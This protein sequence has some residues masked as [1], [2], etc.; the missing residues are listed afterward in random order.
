VWW[1]RQDRVVAAFT[2]SRPDEERNVAAQWIELGQPVSA[3]KLGD[4]SQP[5][6]AASIASAA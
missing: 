1:L 4:S 6:M 3:A 5:I 2:L